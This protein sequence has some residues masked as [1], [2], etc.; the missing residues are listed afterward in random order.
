MMKRTGYHYTPHQCWKSIKREGINPH[1]IVHPELWMFPN[2]AVKGTWIWDRRPRG[3][4]HV[5]M[6]LTTMAKGH[7]RIV[8]LKLRYRQEDILKNPY[9]EDGICKL[10]HTGS[11]GTFKSY[12][13]QVSWIITRPIP[14]KDITKLGEYN[15]KD[16]FK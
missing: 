16:A 11:L 7:D 4:H 13:S 6:I 3:K 10:W 2:K 12:D 14:A 5:G 1:N 15:F 8:F 9:D